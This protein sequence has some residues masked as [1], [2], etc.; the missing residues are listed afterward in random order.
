MTPRRKDSPPRKQSWVKHSPR[1]TLNI[2]DQ[3]TVSGE[4]SAL[5]IGAPEFS[6][7]YGASI[8][9]IWDVGYPL[10]MIEPARHVPDH[11][12]GVRVKE[13]S[14]FGE[15]LHLP[16]APEIAEGKIVEVSLGAVLIDTT[17]KK[18]CA[19]MIKDHELSSIPVFVACVAGIDVI[20]RTESNLIRAFTVDIC[21]VELVSKII[22]ET[23]NAPD[24][25]QRSIEQN[26][27]AAGYGDH[28]ASLSVRTKRNRL[29][30]GNSD[31]VVVVPANAK[32]TRCDP[33]ALGVYGHNPSFK[34]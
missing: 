23:I 10:T 11:V 14:L 7:K 12:A 28:N 2:R 30:Q 8:R 27:S 21:G 13:L 19:G 17:T 3:I 32:R 1:K 15:E 4:E 24:L 16:L 31:S 9:A 26:D 6:N 5:S 33:F 22:A 18:C 20:D 34:L 29:D 25:L